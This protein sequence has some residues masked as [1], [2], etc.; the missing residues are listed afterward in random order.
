MNDTYEVVKTKDI[1]E[2][3]NPDKVTT[4]GSKSK[5]VK[6]TGRTFGA[7][8]NYRINKAIEKYNKRY[9]Q[10]KAGLDEAKKVQ[11]RVLAGDK[12]VNP[13]RVADAL[14][15]AEW[16]AQKLAKLGVKLLKAEGVFKAVRKST[17]VKAKKIKVS[18]SMLKKILSKVEPIRSWNRTRK[19]RKAMRK[20]APDQA[21]DAI[22]VYTDSKFTEINKALKKEPGKVI[23]LANEIAEKLSAV[24]IHAFV[25]G[26]ER[27]DADEVRGVKTKGADLPPVGDEAKTK[28]P[29]TSDE[30]K[31]PDENTGE[32]KKSPLTQA[33]EEKTKEKKPFYLS[34]ALREKT[35]VEKTGEKKDEPPVPPVDEGEKKQREEDKATIKRYEALVGLY[36]QRAKLSDRI[37]SIQNEDL[38]KKMQAYIEKIDAEIG[39]L[40]IVDPKEEAISKKAEAIAN[41]VLEPKQ[42]GEP[43]DVATYTD[44]T[45]GVTRMEEYDKWRKHTLDG[46]SRLFDLQET[47]RG[48]GSSAQLIKENEQAADRKA[49]AEKAKTQKPVSADITPR[50]VEDMK[51]K[52]LDT[53]VLE[54][55][56]ATLRGMLLEQFGYDNS[57]TFAYPTAMEDVDSNN[58][59]LQKR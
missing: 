43:L 8:K 52:Q 45:T 24:N 4:S 46:K 13:D 33:A 55:G 1:E 17:T 42:K 31:K 39:K 10:M 34:E 57:S 36:Q 50:T 7:F 16:A 25:P 58:K 27:I 12:S 47:F 40:T 38:R 37:A 5:V 2:K 49:R 21:E 30:T 56:P 41:Q 59:G 29:S 18:N 14:Y 53:F 6:F 54:P 44:K 22:K 32:K 9:A 11:E 15:D 20:E 35:P 51:G 19:I 48:P 26:H 28:T 3:E 23:D